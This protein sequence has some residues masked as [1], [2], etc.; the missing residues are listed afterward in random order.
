[1]SEAGEVGK[2]VTAL[3]AHKDAVLIA[4]TSYGLWILEGDPVD[5]GSLRC[6]SRD[7]GIVGQ[8]AWTKVG[9][10]IFFLALDGLYSMQANGSDLKNLSGDRLP[11]ELEDVDPV[12]YSVYMG[13]EHSAHGVYVFIE[14][15]QYH[16]FFDLDNGGFWP[17]TLPVAVEAAFI[18]DGSLVVK[19]TSDLLWTFDGE[20]DNG[21]DVES[22]VLFGPFRAAEAPHF[23]AILTAMHGAVE[24][25]HGGSVTWRIVTGDYAE[26]VCRRAQDAVDNYIDGETDTADTVVEES[27]TWSDG[28]SWVSHPRVRGAW[29]VA[30]LSSS[31]V[32]AFDSLLLE[33]Q[34]AGHWR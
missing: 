28:R 15:D 32:W 2:D 24:I 17:F 30:W 1:L 14:G 23:F 11:V 12:N 25:E 19:D 13:Y 6:V 5:G 27:G 9:D 16:W 31:D 29:I 21:T 8:T 18:V 20:D 34:P 3:I 7:V 4:A 33:L 10:T 22:H 26:S